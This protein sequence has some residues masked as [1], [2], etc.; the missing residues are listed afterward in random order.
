MDSANVQ[1]VRRMEELFNRRD[2]DA[3]LELLDAAVEWHVGSEDPDATVHHGR[4]E[5]RAYLDGWIDA[6]ADLRIHTEMVSEADDRVLTMIRFTGQGTGSGMPLDDR[7]SF[8][9]SLRDGYVMKVEDLGR[10]QASTK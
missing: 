2:L 10:V 9:L 4:E 8:A 5:V 7:V 1:V 3:Y 6:F